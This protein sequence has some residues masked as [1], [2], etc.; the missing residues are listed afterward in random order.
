VEPA[1]P[2]GAVDRAAVSVKAFTP[3]LSPEQIEIS[4]EQ[5][6]VTISGAAQ[7]DTP[8]NMRVLFNEFQPGS[9]TRT[10]SLPL[11]ID[12][13]KVEAK[14]EHGVLFLMLSKIETAKPRKIQIKTA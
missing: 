1:L 6:R 11:P 4:V 3:G 13:D 7:N 5:N 9:F 2:I 12:A 14:M 10:F 8:Q